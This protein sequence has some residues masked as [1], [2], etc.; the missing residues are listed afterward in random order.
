M[1]TQLLLTVEQAASTLNLGR[2]VIY[3][4]LMKGEI[5]SLKVGRSRRI[6]ASALNDYV[7]RLRSERAAT[8]DLSS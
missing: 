8:H 2:T 1:T 6:P 3:Q 5:E 7:A 4:L